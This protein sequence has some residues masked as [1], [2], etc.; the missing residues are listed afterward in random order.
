M[1]RRPVEPLFRIDHLGA[2]ST[3]ADIGLMQVRGKGRERTIPNPEQQI[4]Y[5]LQ[6]ALCRVVLLQ[7]RAG[8]AQ[9]V[10]A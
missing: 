9:A 1:D 4:G 10:P 6:P 3:E 8:K 7:R 5:L 2:E